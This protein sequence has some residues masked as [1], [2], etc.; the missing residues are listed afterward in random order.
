[1]ALTYLRSRGV[2]F[3]AVFAFS[4]AVTPRANSS[5]VGGAH[6]GWYWLMATPQWAI[7]HCGSF[8][9]R[10]VNVSADFSNQ[11]ECCIAIARLKVACDSAPHE[12]GK[13]TVPSFSPFIPWC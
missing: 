13:F 3:F 9:A 10:A 12:I 5:L 4:T 6:S 2:A 8:V 1:M 7:A 11:N